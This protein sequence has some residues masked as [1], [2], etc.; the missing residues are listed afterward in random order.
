MEVLVEFLEGDPDKPVV[1]G[2]VFNGKNDAPYP[3]PKHKTKAV[4]R[5]KT[6]KGEGFNEISFEDEKGQEK[7]YMHAERD[8]EIHVENNRAKRIDRNQSESVG[9]NKSIEVGNNHHE[10]IGGNMTLMVG[11][12]RLQSTVTSAF[13]KF[14]SRIGNLASRLGLPDIGSMGEG[15]LVIGVGKNKAET[16]M[17]SSHEVVGAAKTVNVGG[18]YQVSVGGV[19]SESVAMGSMEQVGFNKSTVVGRS[20]E[21]A[22]GDSVISLFSDGSI[23]IR[24]KNILI[25]GSDTV[26]IEGGRVDIN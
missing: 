3:L 7:V 8:H 22:V 10:V 26:K 9:F 4:W 19:K 2:N 1:V 5:S 25:S 16:V 15:N 17:V 18:G 12:N 24:G 11:P 21:I 23:K 13:T 14:T 6:H 20:Y